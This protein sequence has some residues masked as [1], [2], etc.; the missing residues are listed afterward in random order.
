MNFAIVKYWKYKGISHHNHSS[1]IE[2]P[3]W[4]SGSFPDGPIAFDDSFTIETFSGRI[5]TFGPRLSCSVFDRFASIWL[6][7]QHLPMHCRVSLRRDLGARWV[8]QVQWVIFLLEFFG[9]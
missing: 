2:R 9:G 4:S 7:L 8:L 1:P 6:D 3:I 5:L